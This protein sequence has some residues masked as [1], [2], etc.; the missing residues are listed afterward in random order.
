MKR[1]E[2]S[3][4]SGAE[5]SSS[6]RPGAADQARPCR[7]LPQPIP[8]ACSEAGSPAT[9]THARTHQHPTHRGAAAQVGDVGGH[10]LGAARPRLAAQPIPGQVDRGLGPQRRRVRERVPPVPVHRAHVQPGARGQREG[11]QGERRRRVAASGGEQRRHPQVAGQ[12]CGRPPNA[13]STVHCH[14]CGDG[15]L[16][17]LRDEPSDCLDECARQAAPVAAHWP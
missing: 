17:L 4:Q 7:P 10:E 11:E 14:S 2:E 3:W 9:R 12:P 1:D 6:E 8:G 16:S 13:G 15:S 5:F